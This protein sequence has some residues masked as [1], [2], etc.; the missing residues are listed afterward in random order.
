MVNDNSLSRRLKA[1]GFPLLE[2]GE[3]IDANRTLADVVKSHDLRLWEGFPVLLANSAEQNIFHYN[4]VR[5]LLK[6]PSDKSSYDSLVRMSLALYKVC[7]RRFS[8]A[9]S[10]CDMFAGDNEYSL[11]LKAFEKGDDFKLDNVVM[12]A[13]RVKTT[14]DRYFAPTGSKLNE[15]LIEREELG[16]EY[17]LSQIFSPK[18]RDL[19][20]KTEREYFSR[21]VRKKALALANTELHRLARKV[22]E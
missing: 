16:L 17:A 7:G 10:L 19:F 6:T 1:L 11:F 21:V 20:L 3:E 8:W 4:K 13:Q 15:L 2:T 22:L 5:H 14:F 18:Q 12:S 9:D